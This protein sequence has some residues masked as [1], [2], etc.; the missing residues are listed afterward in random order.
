MICDKLLREAFESLDDSFAS[1]A[2]IG[3]TGQKTIQEILQETTIVVSKLSKELS[4]SK[5]FKS[6]DDGA[7]TLSLS[8]GNNEKGLDVFVVGKDIVNADSYYLKATSGEGEKLYNKLWDTL[9]GSQYKYQPSLQLTDTNNFRMTVMMLKYAEKHG[10]ASHLL[11][12]GIVKTDARKVT[13]I[14]VDAR[15]AGKQLTKNNVSRLAENTTKWLNDEILKPLGSRITADSS[16]EALLKMIKDDRAS[17]LNKKIDPDGKSISKYPF[18]L[19]T[20]KLFRRL[21]QNSSTAATSVVFALLL[22]QEDFTTYL[23][24][25]AGEEL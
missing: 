2:P 23:D 16:D 24:K 19:D 11:M 20:L 25:Q 22:K 17:P 15:L 7:G 14:G 12:Q 6:I 3:A 1:V 18:G 21:A 4:K 9:G 8:L 10:D 13:Q 5:R